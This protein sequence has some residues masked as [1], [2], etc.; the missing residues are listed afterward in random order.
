MK[1]RAWMS[2]CLGLTVGA[3]PDGSA[4]F[5]QDAPQTP[6]RPAAQ[7]P[8]GT[9]KRRT[10]EAPTARAGQEREEGPPPF[11]AQQRPP[12]SPEVLE[13][14]KTNYASLC[15]ACHGADARGRR[16]GGVI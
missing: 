16:T 14:G 10:A 7:Q 5:T 8:A 15:S 11:P 2:V 13:R 4:H 6:R 3:E 12:S 1:L 9:Q